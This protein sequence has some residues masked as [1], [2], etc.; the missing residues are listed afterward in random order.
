MFQLMSVTVFFIAEISEYILEMED[1]AT[2]SDKSRLN[3]FPDLLVYSIRQQQ[4]Q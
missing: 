1:D 3:Y 4:F 2:V